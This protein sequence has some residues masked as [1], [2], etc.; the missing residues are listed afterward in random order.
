[1][2]SSQSCHTCSGVSMSPGVHDSMDPGGNGSPLPDVSH[3]EHAA[4]TH[5]HTQPEGRGEMGTM[6]P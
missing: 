5:T 6:S 4:D 3:S 1:M 2:L